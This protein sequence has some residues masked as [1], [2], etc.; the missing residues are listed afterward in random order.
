MVLSLF[1][2]LPLEQAHE[3][4][5]LYLKMRNENKSLFHVVVAVQAHTTFQLTP[6]ASWY[7]FPAG[8]RGIPAL[9]PL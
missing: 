2:Q 1:V 6:V 7:G 4:P 5:K 8:T 3:F 9:D